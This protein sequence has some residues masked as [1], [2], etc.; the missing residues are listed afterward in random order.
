MSNWNTVRTETADD[1]HKIE[2]RYREWG[3][4]RSKVCKWEI[5]RDG[6]KAG[7]AVT[8]QDADANFER[9]LS[10]LVHDPATGAY[11]PAGP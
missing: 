1:G 4:G 2:M 7:Y 11:T 5:Y 6:V 3:K 10:G 9:V 8:A